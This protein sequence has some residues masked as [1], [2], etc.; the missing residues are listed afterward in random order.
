MGTAM[1]R[2]AASPAPP[3]AAS[4]HELVDRLRARETEALGELYDQF[5]GMVYAVVFRIARDTATAE[6][7]TQ[8]V[9]LRI[10]KNIP[11]FNFERGKLSSWVITVARNVGIDHLRSR[12][13]R[14]DLRNISL[15]IVEPLRASLSPEADCLAR[16]EASRVWEA[17][18]RLPARQRQL[19]DLAYRE[20]L[21]QSE[22]AFR[23][24]VPLGTV[25]SWVGG[26][27]RQ[28]RGDLRWREVAAQAAAHTD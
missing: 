21:S 11:S 5:G 10:W 9:F 20:G 27:L 6:D 1:V 13:G 24:G 16:V 8:E 25:K 14:Q 15:E 23:M 18:E 26:A 12:A 17:V 4:A 22:L 3:I 28:L 7:L 2:T 19:L